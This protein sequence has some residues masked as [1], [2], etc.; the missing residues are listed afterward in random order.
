MDKKRAGEPPPISVGSPA[1]DTFPEGARRGQP[2]LA[3]ARVFREGKRD[4]KKPD[5]VTGFGFMVPSFFILSSPSGAGF[6]KF[7]GDCEVCPG[8]RAFLRPSLL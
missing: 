6:D 2:R 7:P 4:I 5:A 1:V 8:G 3:P